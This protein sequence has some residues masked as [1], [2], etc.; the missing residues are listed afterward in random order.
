MQL[1]IAIYYYVPDDD[2]DDDAPILIP[3]ESSS[4]PTVKKILNYPSQSSI[5]FQLAAKSMCVLV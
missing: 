3:R 4:L 1:W 5:L 2:D